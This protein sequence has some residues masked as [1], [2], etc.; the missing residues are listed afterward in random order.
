MYG[1]FALSP[2]GDRFALR[3]EEIAGDTRITGVAGPLTDDEVAECW[4]GDDVEY[5][6]PDNFDDIPW[7]NDIMAGN[8]SRLSWAFLRDL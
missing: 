5:N 2:S 7:A 3:Y 1:L 8:H 6:G 4:F